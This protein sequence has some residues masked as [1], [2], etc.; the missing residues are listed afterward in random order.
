MSKIRCFVVL[1]GHLHHRR[2][3]GQSLPLASSLRKTLPSLGCLTLILDL[4]HVA[5]IY[6]EKLVDLVVI[7]WPGE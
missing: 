4:W 7:T 3:E 2:L 1:V 6:R 5:G